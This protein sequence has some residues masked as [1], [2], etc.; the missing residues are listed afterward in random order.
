[1]VGLAS[2]ARRKVGTISDE[3]PAADPV[4]ITLPWSGQ[5]TNHDQDDDDERGGA[6]PSHTAA[7]AAAGVASQR[8]RRG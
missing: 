5:H 4:D 3:S 1:M 8:G 7:T 6:N 2:K